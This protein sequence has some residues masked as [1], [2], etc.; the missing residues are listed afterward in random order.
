M[1]ILIVV[2]VILTV[3][4]G[5][6]YVAI[7][8]DSNP[9]QAFS[10]DVKNLAKAMTTSFPDGSVIEFALDPQ[11][12]VTEFIYEEITTV[13]DVIQEDGTIIQEN[14]TKKVAIKTST[15]DFQTTANGKKICNLGYTCQI[16]G[17]IQLVDL[18]GDLVSPPYGFFMNIGCEGHTDCQSRRVMVNELTDSNGGFAFVSDS[19]FYGNLSIAGVPAWVLVIVPAFGKLG[20]DLLMYTIGRM[21]IKWFKRKNF[22]SANHLMHKHKIIIFFIVP[23]GGML[24]TLIMFIAG[25]QKIN[26]IKVIPILFIANLISMA[27]FVYPFLF[28]LNLGT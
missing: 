26:I 2:F 24:G 22:A 3:V 19:G 8:S 15:G 20:G 10:D 27:T 5:F 4:L 18:R 6:G 11:P 7:E 13:Q 23:F 16:E 17:R 12:P 21:D 25:H 1:N 14:V 28:Q 9:T